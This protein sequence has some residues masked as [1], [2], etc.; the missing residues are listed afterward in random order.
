MT[1]ISP[2]NLWRPLLV[3]L[4]I[5][6]AMSAVVLWN[7]QVLMERE[8]RDIQA[9]FTLDVEAIGQR[10][11]DRMNTYDLALRGVSSA[12]TGEETSVSHE[13]WQE[14]IKQVWIWD[15][16]PGISSIAWARYLPDTQKESLIA[17][18]RTDGRPDFK[19]FPAGR[20]EHYLVVE[21]IG[22]IDRS[23]IIG[24][25]LFTQSPQNEAITQAVDSGQTTLSR[26]LP[27]LYDTEQDPSEQIGA[28]LYFPVY[29]S[30]NPPLTATERRA[31][32]LGVTS[33]AFRA[34]DLIYGI[35]GNQ[36]QLFYIKAH[37][38]Q[39]DMT[40]FDTRIRQEQR[41]SPPSDWQPR[42]RKEIQL[43]VYGRAWDLE[44]IG[45]P[46]YERGLLAG[47]SHN[48]TLILGLVA[49]A[50]L[51]LLAGGFLYHRDHQ[52]A[53]SRQAANRLREQA[54][55]LILANRYKS[56]FLANMSHELRTP[57][58]SILILS[59][60]LRQNADGSLTEKQIRH[61]AI[62]HRSGND[63]LQLINDV[64]DLAK[65]EAGR[66]QINLEPF[67]L[68]D[69]LVDL[70]AGLHPLAES[71]GLHLHI[72][73][74]TPESSV[75]QRVYTDSIRL[76]Q[77]LRN[78]LSNAIKFTETGQISL[79]VNGGEKLKDDRVMIA[80][81]VRDTG[82]GID[83]A[84]HEELFE[85]FAQFDGSTRRRYGGTGLGLAITRQ[86]VEALDG[87]ISVHSALGQGSTFTVRLP[88]HPVQLSPQK[89]MQPPQRL[90]AGSTV[91]IV[92]DDDT[93]AN[94]IIEKAQDHGF[95]TIHCVTGGQ[96]LELLAEGENFTAIMLDILLPDISGWQLFRRLRTQATYR[97]TPVYIISS[98]P[99]PSEMD[100][101][102]DVHYLTKPIDRNALEK[103]FT[104]LKHDG[105]YGP[106]LLLIEHIEAERDRYCKRLSALGFTVTAHDNARAAREAWKNS[107]FDVLVLDFNLPDKN[108]FDLLETMEA[109]RRLQETRL[110]VTTGFDLSSG[111]LRRLSDHHAV[112]VHKH[113]TD[114]DALAQAVQGFLLEINAVHDQNNAPPPVPQNNL[115]GR[116]LL[117][118]DDDVRNIYAMSAL[119][120]DFGIDVVSASNGEE[121]IASYNKEQL[122]LILM[123]MSM[124]VMDGYTATNLLKNQ[125]NCTIPIIAMTAHAMQGDREKCMAAGTDDY[126]AKPV[127]RE[128][129]RL[130]LEHWLTLPEE[131]QEM[132][133]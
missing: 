62:I 129:L 5:F 61:A 80:F 20:R 75:P 51:S 115:K 98:L 79:E 19:I 28:L 39:E 22:P 21:H 45:T 4:A 44:I 36:L 69:L 1:L 107:H 113:G 111:E 30:D 126:I 101:N 42:F 38:S 49:A 123:D 8:E 12:F 37:D 100:S 56:E 99:H 9:R 124:P 54:R 48:F 117:L 89:I 17:R 73:P 105:S 116:R 32:L 47:R 108:G 18:N 31:T 26:P 76:H 122:D 128:E 70:D 50:L 13:R 102:Q 60:Q 66:M 131:K 67:N 43:P 81:T 92:E 40:I 6:V 133:P 74:I 97:R 104:T 41:S 114:T 132:I 91:L 55:Q 2:L 59:D 63:L 68:Q 33:G 118:V 86:L 71:K 83:P 130:L 77:I 94:L 46:D 53:T 3:S 57:L 23:R 103:L 121:A 82:I 120:D 7:W 109:Q 25:D 87:E 35:F 16:Y 34:R 110:V 78:L 95:S 11:I 93:F 119:L 52:L 88:M 127:K 84:H 85:A 10:V 58:N 106:T 72:S 112:V 65:I 14:I 64:L 24:L 27:D 90:G 96:A 15:L 125:H 29:K